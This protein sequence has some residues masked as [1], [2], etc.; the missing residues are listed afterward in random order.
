MKCELGRG[1]QLQLDKEWLFE[2]RVYNK[3]Y[4]QHQSRIGNN[5]KRIGII[6]DKFFG[7]R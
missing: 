6:K 5:L 4:H 2:S 1:F 3:K 7:G